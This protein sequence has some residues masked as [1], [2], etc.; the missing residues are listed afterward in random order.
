MGGRTTSTNGYGAQGSYQEMLEGDE[1]I[2]ES[3]GLCKKGVTDVLS[4]LVESV[5]ILNEVVELR[6]GAEEMAMMGIRW[7]QAEYEASPQMEMLEQRVTKW[8]G[9]TYPGVEGA[10]ELEGHCG[11]TLS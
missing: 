7:D 8:P 4:K 5:L 1:R 3:K 6:E 9:E 10:G 11:G 2:V